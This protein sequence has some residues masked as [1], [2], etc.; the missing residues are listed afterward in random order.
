M[1]EIIL[2]ATEWK[3]EM[4][5]I[6]LLVVSFF[7]FLLLKQIRKKTKKTENY[8]ETE[9]KKIDTPKNQIDSVLDQA[10]NK[11]PIE[12]VK[13]YFEAKKIEEHVIPSFNETEKIKSFNFSYE[14]D[15]DIEKNIRTHGIPKITNTK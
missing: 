1:K 9:L 12:I 2:N 8:F 4:S 3:E 11:N 7:F 10:Q 5:I 15:Q 6:F 14:F 13:K